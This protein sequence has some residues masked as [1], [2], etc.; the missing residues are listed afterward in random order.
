MLPLHPWSATR[1]AVLLLPLFLAATAAILPAAAA[2][3]EIKIV[4]IGDSN[5]GAP[6]VPVEDKYPT[7]LEAALRAK[8]HDVAVANMGINGDTTAGVL[9]RLSHDVPEGTQI[10]LVAVGVND[11]AVHRIDK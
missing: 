11:Y 7:Q 9:G 10:A 3:A 1:A 6:G 5:L 8:G 2:H 4:A